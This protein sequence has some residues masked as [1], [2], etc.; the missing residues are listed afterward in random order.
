MQGERPELLLTDFSGNERSS[1]Y[2]AKILSCQQTVEDC[3]LPISLLACS[4]KS[5]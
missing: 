2:T 5:F 4:E 3:A 1:L